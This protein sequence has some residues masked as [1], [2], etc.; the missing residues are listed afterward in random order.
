[1]IVSI[2]GYSQKFLIPNMTTFDDKKIHFG[3]TL[4]IN[5]L[6]FGV[7]HYFNLDENP[8]F[9]ISLIDTSKVSEINKVGRQ[10]RTDIST[11]TPGF[12]VGIVSNLRLTENLDL[13][14][15]PGLSFGNRK[16]V[17]N[18]PIHDLTQSEVLKSYSVR[19]TYLDFPL[20]V[21]YKSKRL[22]N[23][24]PYIIG[25][26]AYRIDIARGASD[27]LIQINNSSYYAEFGLGW[28][29]YLQFFRFSTELKFSFGLNDVL[30][31]VPKYPQPAY[32]HD[33]IKKLSSNILTLC[34]HFE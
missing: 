26:A 14:F 1:M 24:R 12:T 29:T 23:Q 13:R 17:Y 4:G 34:F 25:G 3:F 20:L 19:S 33:A 28:D 18:V 7:D 6:D 27:D 10:V 30:G 5:T 31:R 9:D 22:I 11:L 32:Y 21:K 16:M 2:F 15:L 8:S